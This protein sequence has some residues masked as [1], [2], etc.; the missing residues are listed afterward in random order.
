MRPPICDLCG[1]RFDPSDAVA[2]GPLGSQP[3]ERPGDAV[4]ECE[5]A[6]AHGESNV[7]GRADEAAVVREI[8]HS[9]RRAGADLVITYHAREALAGGWIR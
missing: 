7:G 6:D 3:I 8:L 1:K 4:D 2:D 9:I 5:D